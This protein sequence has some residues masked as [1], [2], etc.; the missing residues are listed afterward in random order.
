MKAGDIVL[1]RFPHTDLQKGKLRPALIITQTP[2]RH[3]D[4]LLALITSKIYQ[5]VPEFDEMLTEKDKDF[6]KTRLKTKS[7]IRL[8]RLAT[9]ESTIINARLGSISATR[10]TRI[11]SRLA[12]WIE[13]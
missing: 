12:T 7:V 13:K 6:K 3:A 4:L 5:T 10:L 11:E 8:A 2:G 9:V 1:I